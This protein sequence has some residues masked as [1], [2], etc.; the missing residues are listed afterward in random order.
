MK[1]KTLYRDFDVTYINQEVQ[2]I[3]EG[4]VGYA[5]CLSQ[6]SKIKNAIGKPT[7]TYYGYFLNGEEVLKEKETGGK[8]DFY[9]VKLL[10]R[11]IQLLSYKKDRLAWFEDIHKKIP[12]V[13]RKKLM[14]QETVI[15]VD[16]IWNEIYDII[17]G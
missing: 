4:E 8:P 14:L 5:Y 11:D 13:L 3:K 2:A 7:D 12:P 6:L 1:T 17:V 10:D 15:A 9:A 16:R